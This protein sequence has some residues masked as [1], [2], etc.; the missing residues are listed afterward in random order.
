M[1]VHQRRARE[2]PSKRSWLSIVFSGTR[3]VER[4]L[5][6]IDVVDALADVAALVEQVLIDVGDGGRVGIDA[7]VPGEDPG[8]RGAVGADD[9]DADARLQDAVALRHA[10]HARVEPRPVERVRERADERARG[11]ERQLR[12][13]VERDDVA[14][15]TAAGRA[16]RA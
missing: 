4:C 5:E 16:G 11:V 15:A 6:R 1:S 14:G 3:P 9:V 7:D 8:E 12:V 2:Q 10:L 13:R